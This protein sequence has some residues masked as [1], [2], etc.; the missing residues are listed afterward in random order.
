MTFLYFKPLR[1]GHLHLI[2]GPKVS[3][4]VM[5]IEVGKGYCM[6]LLGRLAFVPA[7]QPCFLGLTNASYGGEWY[8]VQVATVSNSLLKDADLKRNVLYM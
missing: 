5:Y 1:R 3:F 2:A 6:C 8:V 4:T 7:Q